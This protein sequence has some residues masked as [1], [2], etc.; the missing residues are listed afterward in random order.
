MERSRSDADERTHLKIAALNEFMDLL[1]TREKFKQCSM[2][3]RRRTAARDTLR[4]VMKKT[5]QELLADFQVAFEGEA[6]ADARGLTREMYQLTFD[7]LCAPVSA[8]DE[9]DGDRAASSNG[10]P[11]LFLRAV[12]TDGTADPTYLPLEDG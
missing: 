10:A 8:E 5:S 11:K 12:D 2:R 4:E 6:G 3:I 9:G 7:G 1:H